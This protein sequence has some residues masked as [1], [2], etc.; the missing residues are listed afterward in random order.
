MS[1]PS[2]L[3]PNS[4]Y[5][6]LKANIEKLD[7]FQGSS[8]SKSKINLE[9]KI[10]DMLLRLNDM[11]FSLY[12]RI[13]NTEDIGLNYRYPE[14][15]KRYR[16]YAHNKYSIMQNNAYNDMVS[17]RKKLEDLQIEEDELQRRLSRKQIRQEKQARK[18]E[19]KSRK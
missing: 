11:N 19:T 2:S 3:S 18:A 5:E 15:M 7:K 1:A 4:I 9:N 6:R 17:A 8:S 14:L 10:I 16:Q 12:D 13:V